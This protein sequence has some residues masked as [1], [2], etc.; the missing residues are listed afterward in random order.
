MTLAPPDELISTWAIP[1][2]RYHLSE[3][4]HRL[5]VAHT[6]G[7]AAFPTVSGGVAHP[8]F[9]H[10]ATHCGK[11]WT[12]D[13]LLDN[14]RARPTDGVVFGGGTFA[15][16]QPLRVG[17]EYVV[18]ARITDVVRKHGRRIGAF[19]AITLTHTLWTTDSAEVVTTTESFIVPREPGGQV[20]GRGAAAPAP[21]R[22]LGGLVRDVGPVH[23]DD[24]AAIM[25]LMGDTNPVHLD[26]ELAQRAGYRG[27]VNQGPANLAY[28]LAA[29]TEWRGGDIADLTGAEFQFLDTVTA[30]DELRVHGPA[31]VASARQA[32]LHLEIAGTGP[33]LAC[34]VEF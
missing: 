7:R 29:L 19:D 6:H 10:I 22:S 23:V 24:I 18:T 21:A 33:A 13:Q 11:G 17:A 2:G 30:G 34:R 4:R 15:F 25:D 16:Q 26:A 5:M 20:D 3:D 28:V 27:P 12:F 9:A 14:V 31:D 32:E 8:I 1:D